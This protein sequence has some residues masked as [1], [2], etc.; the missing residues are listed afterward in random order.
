MR[1]LAQ[2]PGCVEVGV[3]GAD[4][5]QVQAQRA[6]S[7]VAD[8]GG[9]LERSRRRVVLESSGPAVSATRARPVRGGPASRSGR[10]A[11]GR[12]PGG[13]AHSLPTA[14]I[15]VPQPRQR[16]RQPPAGVRGPR[17]RGPSPAPRAGC[18]T[19]AR[20]ARRHRSAIALPLG[21]RGLGELEAPGEVPVAQRGVLLRLDQPGRGER[22]DRLEQPVARLA[23]RARRP[24]PATC[25]PAG[26]A[27]AGPRR[28]RPFRPAQ[29]ARAAA[30]PNEP[31]N[32][33]SRRST[34]RSVSSS[35]A[36]LQSMDPASVCC[37]RCAPRGTAHE[38]REPVVQARLDLLRGERPQPRRGQLQRQRDPVQV[39]RDRADGRLA[40]TRRAR[41][42]AAR[43]AP[44]R[45]TATAASSSDEGRNPPAPPRPA[46][47][48]ARGW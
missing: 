13:G 5:Q 33:A 7:F 48:A 45:R 42:R 46:R 14:P 27:P 38:Q 37:R 25:R 20:S 4:R 2:L 22:A 28:R 12:S 34:T 11:R 36:W 10:P 43:G 6:Q 21:L 24:P 29:S 39:R 1:L 35:S 18:R 3:E 23:G 30:S 15:E 19:P 8:L 31:A 32:T 41:T 17:P 47:P 40:R 9:Q 16:R 44:D 26:R